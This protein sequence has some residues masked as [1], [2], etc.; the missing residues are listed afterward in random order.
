MAATNRK[1][2]PLV[3]QVLNDR[4]RQVPFGDSE[5]YKEAER[6][7]DDRQGSLQ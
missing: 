5:N 6:E 7:F 1:G 4:R 3:A 2:R